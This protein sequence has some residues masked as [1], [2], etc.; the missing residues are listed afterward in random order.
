[1]IFK[2]NSDEP[3]HRT[4][5]P[6]TKADVGG[7]RDRL[8]HKGGSTSD[9]GGEDPEL[10]GPD[11]LAACKDNDNKR[12][13]EL[14]DEGVPPGFSD[15]ESGKRKHDQLYTASAHG[16]VRYYGILFFALRQY[17][18]RDSVRHNIEYPLPVVTQQNK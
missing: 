10:L 6:H 13:Q 7:D 1:M 4:I 12:A 3:S 11:L 8:P 18:V 14:I 9:G 17:I 2:I 15:A 5:H 16:A